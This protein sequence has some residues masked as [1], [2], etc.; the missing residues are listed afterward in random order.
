MTIREMHYDYKQ[1]L[2]KID[3]QKYRDLIVPEIDWKLNEA[4]EV[5]VKIIAEPRLGKKLGFEFN[6]RTIDDIRTIVVNQ[7]ST[8][9]ISLSS[10]DS[11]SFKGTLPTDYWFLLK[12]RVIATKGTCQ[13]KVLRTRVVQH[14]DETEVSYFDKSSFVWR[15]ANLR[16]YE[17]GIR[18]FTN[19]DFTPS[20]LMMDYLKEP[21][22]VHNA[23]DFNGTYTTLT[24]IPLIG[25][26]D[27]M[28]P[29]VVHRDIVDLAVFIT[30]NDLNLANY[31]FKKDKL[32]FTE[33]KS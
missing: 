1:K 2:N 3:S 21:E 29:K 33:I 16:F 10:F 6:Q 4:Q 5:F 17:G 28:L 26:K 9:A 25:S 23:Q 24:G 14:D 15:M 20:K 31:G 18:V 13:D 22:S 19:G 27:C 32:S 7:D 12:A 8:N 30:A 11:S